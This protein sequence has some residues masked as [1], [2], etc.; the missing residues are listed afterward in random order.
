MEDALEEVQSYFE[1]NFNS[2]LTTVKNERSD[3]ITKPPAIIERGRTR[4]QTYPKIELLPSATGHDYGSSDAPLVKPWLLHEIIIVITHVSAQISTVENTLLRYSEV[5]NR[6]QEDDDTFGQKFTWLQIKEED[7]TPMV[8]NQEDRK[9]MQSILI[10][11]V[12][13]TL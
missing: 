12:C 5:I 1:D 11:I 2:K 9:M 4:K 13:R 6:L 8:E 3:N 7:Y 10:P